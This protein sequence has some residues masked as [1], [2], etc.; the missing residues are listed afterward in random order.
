MLNERDRSVLRH[1]MEREVYEKQ[2]FGS[3]FFR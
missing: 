1:I 3:H 2:K